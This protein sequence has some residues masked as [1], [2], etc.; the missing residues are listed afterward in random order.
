MVKI[1][2]DLDTSADNDIHGKSFNSVNAAINYIK[3]NTGHFTNG[4]VIAVVDFAEAET[5]FLEARLVMTL[6]KI[7]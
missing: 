3:V 2:L 7:E 1:F 5:I 4:D 6:N